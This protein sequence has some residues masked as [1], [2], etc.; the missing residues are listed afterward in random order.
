[1]PAVDIGIFVAVDIPVVWISAVDIL[2]DLV[3]VLGIEYTA[4]PPLDT[5]EVEAGAGVFWY[6]PPLLHVCNKRMK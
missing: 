2:V 3:V 5:E 1:M 4:D 6:W